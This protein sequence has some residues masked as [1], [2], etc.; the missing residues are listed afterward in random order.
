MSN[1]R[2]PQSRRQPAAPAAGTHAPTYGG[3]V[4]FVRTLSESGGVVLE[5]VLIGGKLY[6]RR[7]NTATGDGELRPLF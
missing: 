1:P 3:S 2:I 6:E 7:F 5:E 4:E